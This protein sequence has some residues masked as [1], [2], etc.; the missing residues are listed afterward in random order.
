MEKPQFTRHTPTGMSTT[1]SKNCLGPHADSLTRD[2]SCC[3]PMGITTLSKYTFRFSKR[4]GTLGSRLSPP[5]A[6]KPAPATSNTLSTSNC[7]ISLICCTV[8]TK[9]LGICHDRN[10]P[11]KTQR[12]SQRAGTAGGRLSQPQPARENLCDRSTGTSV[13]STKLGISMVF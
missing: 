10:R 1:L 12:F 3:T 2:T 7:G 4:A 8:E 13:V 5:E 9:G 6:E 11:R